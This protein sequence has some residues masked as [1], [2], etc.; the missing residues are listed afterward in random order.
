M[1]AKIDLSL[2]K[3]HRKLAPI[4][5]IPLLLSALT[6]IGYRLGKSWF[7]LSSEA[8]DIFMVIHQGEYLGEPIKPIYV[9]L[10]G[11]GAV[12]ILITGLNLLKQQRALTQFNVRRIHRSLAPWFALPFAISAITGIIYRIGKS[13][14]G[15]SSETAEIFMTIHQGAYLG[16]WF[17][18]IYV[19]LV[20]IGLLVMLATGLEMTG[21]L[22]R[23]PRS[24]TGQ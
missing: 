15:M 11:L 16:D 7:G 14:F 2:R 10:V 24:N 20:G 4:L 21:L 18:P 9:L 3:F 12:A 8:A 6:G 19:L 13:W 5:F 22:R 17:K 23:K 1:S